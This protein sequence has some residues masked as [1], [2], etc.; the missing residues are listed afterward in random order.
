MEYNVI[1]CPDE[2]CRSVNIVEADDKDT[3]LC[4]GCDS[5]YKSEKY[6]I[7]YTC[8]KHEKAVEAR[9]KLLI[10]IND[11]DFTYEDIREI[12]ENEDEKVFKKRNNRDTRSPKLIIREILED[13]DNPT[14]EDVIDEATNMERFDEDQVDKI[15]TSL[16]RDGSVLD[17]G[18][19]LKLI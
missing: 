2:R 19:S 10:K 11:D 5:Q 9:T 8:S 12:A 18:D 15:I 4:S 14:R 1:V 3:I 6:K 13:L 16:V 7:A 17:Y